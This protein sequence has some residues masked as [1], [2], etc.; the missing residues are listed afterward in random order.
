MHRL[1]ARLSMIMGI[2][3]ALTFSLMF[4]VDFAQQSTWAA[5]EQQDSLRLARDAIGLSACAGLGFLAVLYGAK[6]LLLGRAGRSILNE[7]SVP[8]GATEPMGGSE[9]VADTEPLQ[10]V[11]IPHVS[12]GSETVLLIEDHEELRALI[13]DGLRSRGYNVLSAED[14]LEALRIGNQ[15][16]GPIHVLLTDLVM[17][18]MS[19][20]DMAE[21]VTQIRPQMRVLYMAENASDLRGALFGDEV[22]F[23]GTPVAIERLARR[24]RRV[25]D[26]DDR[27]QRLPPGSGDRR[28]A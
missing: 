22:A 1:F 13:A 23:L 10:I 26:D 14:T 11:R 5:S 2:G 7:R 28:T 9:R 19:G 18:G 12:S 25:L 8:T 20:H 17:P 16:V 24:L 4:F 21:L 15:Y 27:E 6:V 3:G